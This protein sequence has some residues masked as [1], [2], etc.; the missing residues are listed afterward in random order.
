MSARESDECDNDADQH[1]D[2]NDLGSW[3]IPIDSHEKGAADPDGRD[4]SGS[5]GIFDK[6][7]E[8]LKHDALLM[9]FLLLQRLAAD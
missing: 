5:I 2:N 1:I 4:D 7:H 8:F 6:K 3:Q 9:N